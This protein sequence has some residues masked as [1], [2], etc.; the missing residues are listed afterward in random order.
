M[1]QSLGDV[2]GDLQSK[3][4]QLTLAMQDLS[5]ATEEIKKAVEFRSR[6]ECLERYT[7]QGFIE[8]FVVKIFLDSLAYAKIKRV[9]TRVHYKR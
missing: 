7:V 9:K 2:F 4:L 6:L 1:H 3:D 5:I 8:Y